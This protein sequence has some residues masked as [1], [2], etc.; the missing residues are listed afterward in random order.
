MDRLHAMKV[1]TRVVETNSFTRAADAL[2]LPR[3]SVS[4]TIQR[5]ENH[6]NVRLLQR[7]TR[8]VALTPHGA[9]YYQ[10]C[11][12]ILADVEETEGSFK[13][14]SLAASGR[15]RVDI[16]GALGHVMVL[17]KIREFYACYPDI[18]LMLGFGERNVDL[19]QEGVDC[20]IRVG[21]LK[22]SDLVAKH[23]GL[24]Q[25]I[26]VA[27]P[28]YLEL[29]GTPT[30]I[31]KLDHHI[32]TNRF[33]SRTGKIASLTFSVGGEPVEVRMKGHLAV[34]DA[35]AHLKSALDGVGIIQLGRFTATPY[36]QSGRLIEI[37]PRSK[38]FPVP[39]SAVY[40]QNRHISFAV[41]AFID[42][43]TKIFSEHALRSDTEKSETQRPSVQAD[44]AAS[45]PL[46]LKTANA[47][48][49]TV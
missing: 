42:W 28:A 22:D 14:I 49:E 44:H 16:P 29:Y 37:L 40:P 3:A 46:H 9:G 19:I 47:A 32:A 27:S 5:L 41:R 48:E 26:T 35:E 15:L 45:K 33:S 38:P 2:E 34:N 20:A 11:L 25:V 12:R 13:D 23:V 36:L 31:E 21:T 7:T 6:L 43:I 30:T 10:R 39:I 18:E 17:P 24:Y 1:F 8:R 4:V